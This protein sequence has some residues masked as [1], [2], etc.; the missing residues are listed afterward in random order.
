MFNLGLRP[1]EV[2]H[3]GKILID[4]VA[5]QENDEAASLFHQLCDLLEKGK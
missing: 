3:L 4:A 2:L 5:E 1:H